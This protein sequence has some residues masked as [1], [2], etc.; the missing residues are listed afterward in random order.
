MVACTAARTCFALR[1]H[2]FQIHSVFWMP[3]FFIEM[4]FGLSDSG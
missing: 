4:P 1:G 3:S 2:V